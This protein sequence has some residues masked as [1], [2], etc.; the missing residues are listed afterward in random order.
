MLNTTAIIAIY[1]DS[2][3]FSTSSAQN[4]VQ[5]NTKGSL[6]MTM[7]NL[8]RLISLNEIE[9]N[10]KILLDVEL[11]QAKDRQVKL[12]RGSAHGS[13]VNEI[14]SL[15]GTRG[16]NPTTEV[17]GKKPFPLDLLK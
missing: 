9:V 10:T 13:A 5:V 15:W 11:K 4:S 12:P 3:H 8:S 6:P 2:H 14:S 16:I 1:D 17:M 7:S